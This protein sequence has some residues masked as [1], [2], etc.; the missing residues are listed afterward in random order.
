M[1]VPGFGKAD[2]MPGCNTKGA[3]PMQDGLLE[4]DLLT[5]C[6][7]NVQW[8]AISSQPVKGSLFGTGLLL[9]GLIWGSA[10]DFAAGRCM[11]VR[12][13]D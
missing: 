13:C 3:E 8:I 2:N 11:M 9:L 1:K 6:W 10:G 4:A 12:A 5:D 7:V